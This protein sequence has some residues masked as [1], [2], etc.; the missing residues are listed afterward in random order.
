MKSYVPNYYKYITLNSVSSLLY[1]FIIFSS[2]YICGANSGWL[3]CIKSIINILSVLLLFNE[4]TI[5]NIPS[6]VNWFLLTS[7]FL[8]TLSC[9]RNRV[10]SATALSFTLLP[11]MDSSLN[12]VFLLL[13]SVVK[14]LVAP[15]D[16][17]W[18]QLMYNTSKVELV[19]RSNPSSMLL[20][21]I[22]NF[23]VLQ[24]SAISTIALDDCMVSEL[25]QN[26]IQSM[27][28]LTE[29]SD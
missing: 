17:R 19:D 27:V 23:F 5:V 20:F 3:V 25:Y 16:V 21:E 12:L 22:S 15:L 2:V 4:H 14:I 10:I 26:K 13:V 24:D 11:L 1:L 7:S 6:V 18:V 8:R 29:A 9:F 28:V